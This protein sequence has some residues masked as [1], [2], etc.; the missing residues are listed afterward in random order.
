MKALLAEVTKLAGE[1]NASVTH[2][3]G[4]NEIWL[5]GKERAKLAKEVCKFNPTVKT[6]KMSRAIAL[7]Y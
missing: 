7:Y 5:T 6:L 4:L 3:T 1:F 2:K